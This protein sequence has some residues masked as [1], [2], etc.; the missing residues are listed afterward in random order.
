MTK[1]RPPLTKKG[2]RLVT[3][4]LMPI[5]L[6]LTCKFLFSFFVH[7]PFRIANIFVFCTYVCY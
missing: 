7:K 5:M 1:A 3:E 4:G 2:L 6:L